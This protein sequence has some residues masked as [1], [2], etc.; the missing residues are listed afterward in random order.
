MRE[1]SFFGKLPT[2]G[3][4][5]RPPTK[6]GASAAFE[7]WAHSAYGALR[8][9]GLS[10]LPAPVYMVMPHGGTSFLLAA[11][12]PSVDSVGRAFPFGVTCTIP[13]SEVAV[14]ASVLPIAA[15]RFFQMVTELADEI[16]Q[17]DRTSVVKRVA[18]IAPVSAEEERYAENVCENTRHSA[19]TAEF[20]TAV[21][22]SLAERFYA[23]RTLRMGVAANQDITLDCPVTRDVDLFVW[24]EL[25]H[26]ARMWRPAPV[27]WTIDPEPRLL[28]SLAEPP[29]Q[30]VAQLFRP[31]K[32]ATQFWPLRTQHEASLEQAAQALARVG[33]W[34]RVGEPVSMLVERVAGFPI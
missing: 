34:D 21:F 16:E 9:A 4:F 23:Y 30:A 17:L 6:T 32:S 15:D 29:V 14:R 22:A 25:V 10:G 19:S 27:L 33:A 11:M 7:N 2:E 18:R 28:I 5:V 3:D 31:D 12:I 13:F 1:V 24:T 26:A 8:M 20:E